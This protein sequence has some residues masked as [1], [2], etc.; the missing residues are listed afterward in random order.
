M[1]IAEFVADMIDPPDDTWEPL[2]HQ[3]A[4]PGRW[5]AWLLLGGRGAGK[6]AAAARDMH[7]H[8]HG[9]PCLPDVPGGHWPAIIAPTLGDGVTSCVNGPS[10]L[11]KHNPELKLSVTPG[12]TV[13]RWPNGVEAKIFGAHT[14]EDV[15]RLRS[16]GN[17]CYVWAEELAAWR[18]IQECWNHM[19]YGLRIGPWPHVVISTTPK[20]KMLIKELVRA[21][22][23]VVTK[24]STAEN[25]HL[26]ANVKKALFED[27]GGTR[28]GRQELYAD[29]LDDAPG[30]LWTWDDIDHNRIDLAKIP[31]YFSRIAVG[32]DPAASSEGDEN[33]IVVCGVLNPFEYSDSHMD[34][35]DRMH[36]FVLWDYS[37]QGGPG[38]WSKE[39]VRA[40]HDWQANIAVPEINNGGEMV[41]HTIRQIDPTIPMAGPNGVGVHASRGKTKRAE[42]VAMLYQ[43]G[44]IHHV[45]KFHELEDQ[46]VSW[47]ALDPDDSWSPDRM[48][49]MV[50]AFTELMIRPRQI[51]RMYAKDN[52]LRGRR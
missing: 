43:Q 26:D 48:D 1:S 4:P 34:L 35:E 18:Y 13:V 50:W 7:N 21:E 45:G 10:G 25:P 39:V 27:Y 16:G 52:R 47:D 30:A 2:P 49:A 19:R 14:P 40:Y 12:G 8:V 31:D 3:I 32:I 28:E 51:Q 20:P 9:P 5:F 29:I 44:L 42:P 36:G 11:R 46:M 23:V 17:R 33:G 37:S 38:W 22:N 15:E 24:A 6:T 41:A